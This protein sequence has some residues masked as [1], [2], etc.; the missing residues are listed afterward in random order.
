M[1]A[2]LPRNSRSGLPRNSRSGLPR[3]SR[4][5][6]PPDVRRGS[7]SPLTYKSGEGYAPRSGLP[8]LS[9]A[10][11]HTRGTA[12]FSFQVNGKAKPCR[13]SG[14]KPLRQFCA[15]GK[16]LQ[17]FCSKAKVGGKRLREFCGKPRPAPSRCGNC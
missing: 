6:L 1:S 5:G 17:E 16:P 4:S 15:D 13:T 14:G 10:K 2:A 12:P 11:G 7:A 9:W 8:Q 3:N